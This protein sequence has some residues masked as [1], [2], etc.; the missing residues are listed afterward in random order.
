MSMIK[1]IVSILV[2]LFAAVLV[3]F[4]VE[5]I[6]NLIYPINFRADQPLNELMKSLPTGALLFVLMAWFL[7]AMVGA[8][9]ACYLDELNAL[10]S[11]IYVAVFLL[12][13][14][15]INLYQIPHPFWMWFAGILSIIAGCSLGVKMFVRYWSEKQIVN[16]KWTFEK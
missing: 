16:G 13:A 5:S 6:S 7:G 10:R 3:I 15:V 14:T 11:S 9:L 8:F 1:S 12:I 4:L 2:G